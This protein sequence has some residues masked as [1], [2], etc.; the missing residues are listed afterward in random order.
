LIQKIAVNTN[1]PKSWKAL[2][3]ERYNGDSV[4]GNWLANHR[5]AL[6]FLIR[7]LES[8]NAPLRMDAV[9]VVANMLAK[10][11]SADPFPPAEYRSLKQRIHSAAAKGNPAVRQSAIQG[12]ALT[13]DIE[14]VPFLEKLA[15]A[16]ADPDTRQFALAA[17]R[18]VRDSNH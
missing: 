4:F 11:K 1:N 17:A 2:V 9:Y 7:R 14:D 13:K 8:P 5:A 12:L 18:Q 6:P 10:A 15:K 16:A 3:Y